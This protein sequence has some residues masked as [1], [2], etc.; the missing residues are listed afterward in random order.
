MPC[1]GFPGNICGVCPRKELTEDRFD[2]GKNASE[3][4]PANF[5]GIEEFPLE[6]DAGP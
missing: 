5:A 4:R 2:C 6:N 3:G 1:P